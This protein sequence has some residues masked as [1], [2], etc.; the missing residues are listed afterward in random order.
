MEQISEQWHTETNVQ[1]AFVNALVDRGW[2]ILSVKNTASREGGVDV[3]ADRAGQKVGA[4]VKGY[5]TV[6][7]ADP[8]RAGE[9]RRRSHRGRQ[10]IGMPRQ[11]WQ[12]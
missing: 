3:I 8:K 9:K 2:R 1:E 12:Q 11:S 4:E 7:Y 5:P 10:G 6:G